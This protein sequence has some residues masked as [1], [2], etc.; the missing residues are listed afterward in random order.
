MVYVAISDIV[1]MVRKKTIATA[2]QLL[3]NEL[4]WNRWRINNS[5]AVA[6]G[7]NFLPSRQRCEPSEPTIKKV[8]NEILEDMKS[9]KIETLDC[10]K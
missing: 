2:D 7:T 8:Y 3:R 6:N 1:D 10:W 9:I 5:F 4:S